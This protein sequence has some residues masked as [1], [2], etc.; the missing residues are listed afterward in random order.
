MLASD[1]EADF[2]AWQT[3]L[4]GTVQHSM[5]MAAAYIDSK[6]VALSI[7]ALD[8]VGWMLM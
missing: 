4:Q 5:C 6:C 8:Y 7:V 3:I 2:S 1:V